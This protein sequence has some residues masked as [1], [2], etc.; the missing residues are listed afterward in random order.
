[1]T[2]IYVDGSAALLPDAPARLAHLTQA[3]HDVILVSPPDHR[4]A[5]LFAWE[6]HVQRL[7]ED[8]PRGAWF[9]TADPAT[10]G[11]RQ[12]GLATLLIGPREDN[13]RPTRCDQTARDLTSAVLEILARDAMS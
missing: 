2:T 12:S 1:M 11:H 9:M 13:P 8:P 7:P 10:C 5:S 3:G 6:A 4:S